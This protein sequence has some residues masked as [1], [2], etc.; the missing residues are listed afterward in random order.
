M[1]TDSQKQYLFAIYILGSEGK[2]V[3]STCVSEF[4]GVS[5]ASTVKMTQRI[6]RKLPVRC[7]Y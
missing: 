5:K 1:L 6:G 4:L 2:P 7:F 3:K